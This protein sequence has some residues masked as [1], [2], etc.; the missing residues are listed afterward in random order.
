[1]RQILKKMDGACVY[2]LGILFKLPFR[3]VQYFGKT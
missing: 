1:M 2:T 3:T